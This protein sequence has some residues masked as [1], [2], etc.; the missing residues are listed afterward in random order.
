[1]IYHRVSKV[2]AATPQLA[3]KLFWGATGR[4]ADNKG[5]ELLLTLK[6]AKLNFKHKC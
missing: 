2:G 3:M 4:Q 5:V 1:M 6:K